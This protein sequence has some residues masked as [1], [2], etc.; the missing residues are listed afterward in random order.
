MPTTPTPDLAGPTLA[1]PA[2]GSVRGVWWLSPLGAVV[3]VT[4]PVLVVANSVSPWTF[5]GAWRTPK[6]LTTQDLVLF[7][8]GAC[9][10]AIASLVGLVGRRSRI[11]GS[12]PALTDATQQ[13]LHRAAT[14]LFWLTIFGYVVF[15]AAA[16]LRGLRLSQLVEVLT[17]QN[18]V[19]SGVKETYFGT[20]PG[21]TT[22]TQ[23]GIAYVVVAGLLL[24]SAWNRR[25]AIGLGVVLGLAV[26]R[27]YL[28]AERLAVLELAIPLT[29]IVVMQLR[30]RS[31][32][33][34]AWLI[35]LMPVLLLPLVTVFF[36]LYEYS[37]SWVFYRQQTDGTFWAFAVERLQG[38][39]LTAVNNGQILLE[40]SIPERLPYETLAAFWEAPGIG[41]LGL[42]DG[43]RRRISAAWATNSNSMETLSS[44]RRAGS[45]PPSLTGESP[46][47]SSGWALLGS[48]WVSCIALSATLRRS[49][50]CSI[51]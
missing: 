12:W 25:T 17:A 22:L 32:T 31:G 14:V 9:V 38:Y 6:W 45:A 11:D 40:R 23:V 4:I 10:F 30:E 15:V 8:A 51:R 37:R 35:R 46:G 41:T 24:S 3:L 2:A 29:A 36:G 50:S 33:A 27:G 16:I 19:G 49:D 13:R 18:V 7:G 1:S 21:V 5:V 48:S 26:A 44:T 34:V 28:L 47:G 42:Y 39:Y 43:L 20:I